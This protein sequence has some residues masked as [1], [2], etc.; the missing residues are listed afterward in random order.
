MV[1]RLYV[2]ITLL[3]TTYSSLDL[4]HHEIF[5]A[6]GG[7]GGISLSVG[8]LAISRQT[9]RQKETDK[10]LILLSYMTYKV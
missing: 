2:E 7:K 8:C 1:I 6:K 4:A 10:T 9:D 5:C 3:Y